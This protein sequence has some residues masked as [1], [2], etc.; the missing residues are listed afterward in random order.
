MRKDIKI[1]EVKDVYV[2]A[3]LD[4]NEDFNTHDWNVYLIN[5][6]SEA[7]ETVLIV[8]Q[9]YD[10]KDMTAPMRHTIKVVP[11]KGYA[12]IEFL[13]ESVFR[14]D[15]FFTITYFIG[16][17]MFDKRFEL[18]ANSIMKENTVSLPVMNKDGVLA[19]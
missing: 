12:K 6:G 17:T 8:S 16:N 9:G 19:R 7:I 14:L 2:A 15:N 18:P 10:D 13:D 1:P 3:V 11:A 5:D 4:F